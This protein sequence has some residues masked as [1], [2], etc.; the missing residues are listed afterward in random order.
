MQHAERYESGRGPEIDRGPRHQVSGLL[1]VVEPEVEALELVEEVVPEPVLRH[2]A[3]PL[4]HVEGQVAQYGP[5]YPRQRDL[6]HYQD[7]STLGAGQRLVDSVTGKTRDRHARHDR[8]G[9]H[10]R[11]DDEERLVRQGVPD[12]PQQDLHAKSLPGLM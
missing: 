5:G 11:R 3:D 1:P 12:Q 8:G 7:Q 4:S 6:A 2:P 10:H 9:H